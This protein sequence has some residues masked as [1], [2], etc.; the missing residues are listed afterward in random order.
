MWSTSQNN[1]TP[2]RFIL[3]NKIKNLSYTFLCNCLFQYFSIS[4]FQYFLN[5]SYYNE[6]R[7][8]SVNCP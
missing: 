2:Q 8:L 7:N 5:P 4:L 3:Q 6:I 1:P